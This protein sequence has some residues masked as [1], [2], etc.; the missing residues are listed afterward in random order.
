MKLL[1][2]DDHNTLCDI[3]FTVWRDETIKQIY[4]NSGL[5][6]Y[7]I[8]FSN[9]IIRTKIK[10]ICVIIITTHYRKRRSLWCEEFVRILLLGNKT[11][12]KQSTCRQKVSSR[13]DYKHCIGGF[14]CVLFLIL[15]LKVSNFPRKA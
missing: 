5:Q 10:L 9:L 2:I 6:N 15:F 8:F 14:I 3:S 4:R 11:Y 1:E 13:H 7:L 12:S